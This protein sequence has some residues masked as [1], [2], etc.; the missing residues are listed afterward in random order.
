MSPTRPGLFTFVKQQF[1]PVCRWR[2]R[3]VYTQAHLPGLEV[4]DHTQLHPMSHTSNMMHGSD[5]TQECKVTGTRVGMHVCLYV[6]VWMKESHRHIWSRLR[7]WHIPAD[8]CIRSCRPCW[9]IPRHHTLQIWLYIRRYLKYNTMIH[10]LELLNISRCWCNRNCCR[11]QTVWTQTHFF[12]FLEKHLRQ[13]LSFGFYDASI[14]WETREI[15]ILASSIS[16]W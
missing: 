13:Q 5:A 8:R 2:D 11:N 10:F 1:C 4:L 9:Y 7:W 6:C 15:C 12:S 14:N 3:P 16:S